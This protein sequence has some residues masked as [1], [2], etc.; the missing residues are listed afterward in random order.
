MHFRRSAGRPDAVILYRLA[1]TSEPGALARY[2]DVRHP[3]WRRQ[4]GGAYA[5]HQSGTAWTANHAALG[6]QINRIFRTQPPLTRPLDM[7]MEDYIAITLPSDLL[8]RGALWNL[9]GFAL[10]M[11]FGPPRWYR[12]C[13]TATSSCFTSSGTRWV[14]FWL[15]CSTRTFGIS[16][17]GGLATAQVI[18]LGLLVTAVVLLVVRHHLRSRK[19]PVRRK[20]DC[21]RCQC[22]VCCQ[23][24]HDERRSVVTLVGR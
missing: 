5:P 24:N 19:P 17:F 20:V 22:G 7:S 16:G 8:L 9:F 6:L 15:R 4:S 10:V 13:W 18:N 21:G 14:V 23:E 2:F 12:S 3:G 1:A 11:I